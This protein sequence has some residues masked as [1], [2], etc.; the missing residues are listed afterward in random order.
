[1]DRRIYMLISSLDGIPG[2]TLTIFIMVRFRGRESLR[3][4]LVDHDLANV[5][6]HTEIEKRLR[7]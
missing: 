3:L 2:L 7:I 5:P 6:F 4:I 1:V